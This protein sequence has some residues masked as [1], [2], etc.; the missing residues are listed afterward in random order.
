L[1]PNSRRRDAWV[2]KLLRDAETSSARLLAQGFKSRT[3]RDR[4]FCA[5][6]RISPSTLQRYR[7][8]AKRGGT[9]HETRGRRAGSRVAAIGPKA[10]EFFVATTLRLRL[11]VAEAMRIVQGKALEQAGDPAWEFSA[12]YSTVLRRLQTEFPDFYRDYVTRDPE[13]W[14]ALHGPKLDRRQ[15]DQPA[16]LVWEVDG[17]PSNALGRNGTKV[18]RLQIVIVADPASR[19][20]LGCAV[21]YSESTELIRRA[22]WEAYR[23]VGASK[24]VRVD[25][26]K[27]F[28]GQ[29]VGDF[30]RRKSAVDDAEV[31]GFVQMLQAELEDTTGRSPWQKGFVESLMRTVD[32][33]HDRL[34]RKAYVGNRP[35]N[36]SRRVDQWARK[37]PEKL[38]TRDE[39][40]RT[41]R[42][43]WEAENRRPR[44]D[45]GG[46]SPLHVFQ[47]T[48]IPERRLPQHAEEFL[49]RRPQRVTVT[50]KGVVVTIGG[51]RLHYGHRDPR[52]WERQGQKLI[53]YI[54]ESDTADVLL[55]DASGHP[56]FYA[57]EDTLSGTD[58]ESIAEA[59]KLQRKARKRARERF[60]DIDLAC[61]PTVDVALD[62]KRKAAE[63]EAAK[64]DTGEPVERGRIILHS[65]FERALKRA[66][67]Q[68][69]RATGTDDNTAEPAATLDDLVNLPADSTDAAPEISWNDLDSP[70][71]EDHADDP[72]QYFK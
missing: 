10:W 67:R 7:R 13:K 14:A 58:A 23:A 69:R 41:L 40:E 52:V 33:K 19:M 26:G 29:G 31:I 43:M 12:S 63:A 47:R 38:P 35:E 21:G 30:R 36:R 55:C 50:T 15:V 64:T 48:A 22:M 2:R 27:A 34:Y 32:Q 37:H 6:R 5:E 18:Q 71:T 54:D 42:A 3:V 8:I 11:D 1:A 51:V 72:L 39:Y 20:V 46:L 59:G 65:K 68:E 53:A 60:D 62:L 17:T 24:I 66:K 57:R 25:Q 28:A 45:L 61:A 56:L 16:N 49:R 70:V 9:F 4:I 44:P